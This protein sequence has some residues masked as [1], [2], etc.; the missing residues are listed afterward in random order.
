MLVFA[1][2]NLLMAIITGIGG[3]PNAGQGVRGFFTLGVIGL[4]CLLIAKNKK[5]NKEDK[6]KWENGN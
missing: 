1:G 6:D 3:D 5:K 4:V 2:L